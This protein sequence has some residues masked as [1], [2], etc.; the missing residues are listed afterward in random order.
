[1]KNHG[2]L[3]T[4]VMESIGQQFLN[5]SA[6]QN[7]LEGL[8]K[9]RLLPTH[10]HQSFWFIKSGVGRIIYISNK[11]PGDAESTL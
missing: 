9:C 8:S 3:E 4:R 7:H 11:F 10:P 2:N 5:W 6:Y 1:M